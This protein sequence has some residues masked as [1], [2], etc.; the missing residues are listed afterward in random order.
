M[1]LDLVGTLGKLVSI[2]SVNPMGRT[3]ARSEYF[4]TR[5]TDYLEEL[6]RGLGLPVERQNVHPDR[7]NILT[8]VDGSPTP[9]AGGELILWEAHQD[10]VPVDGMTIEPW[11]PTIQNGRMQGRGSCDVKGGMSAM[12]HALSRLAAA[13]SGR[14]PTI[15]FAATINEE[16]GFS[17]AKALTRHWHGGSR[18]LPRAPDAAIV[19]EPTDL[20]VVVAHKGAVRWR[21]HS[22]GKATHSSRPEQGDNAIYRMCRVIAALERY[23]L[24]VATNLPGHP[25]CGRPSLSVGTIHGGIS[26]NTVP[27]RCQ[28]EIDRRI[29][30]G[31]QPADIYRA[32]VDYVAAAVAH[33]PQVK[34]DE[35][36]MSGQGLSDQCNGP[37]AERLLAV[38]RRSQPAAAIVGVPYGTDAAVLSAAGVPC[39]VFGPGSIAQAHTEDEWIDLD[40]LKV[41][42]DV[43]QRFAAAEAS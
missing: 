38:A 2:P 36:F 34:H 35:P 4:E 41:A 42:S 7:D 26:V 31:E 6:F 40:E 21:C 3:D 10:T 43:L 16:Y 32:V 9:E 19:A 17:G 28:I 1:T 39:V 29:I 24:E 20:H 30:P 11:T 25:R 23:Q 8:R 14:R 12:L 5:V 22:S 15:V 33:D 27:D 18:L 37:L 13:G